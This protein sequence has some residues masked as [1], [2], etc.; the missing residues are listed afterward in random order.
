MVFKIKHV[1]KGS[2]LSEQLKVV[3]YRSSSK[4]EYLVVRRTTLVILLD[5]A[6]GTVVVEAAVR[7]DGVLGVRVKALVEVTE[8]VEGVVVHGGDGGDV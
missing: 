8:G 6:L 7:L 3:A 1:Y 2:S 4:V 5:P